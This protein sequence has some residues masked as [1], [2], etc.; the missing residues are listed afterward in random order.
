MSACPSLEELP[1]PP[2]GKSGWPWTEESARVVATPDRPV[3]RVTVITPSFNQ[4]AYVEETIRSVL[5]Q[6]YPDLEYFVLDGGSTDGSAE[7]IRNYAPW[8]SFWTSERDGGQSAAINR[9]LRLGTGVF[10]AWINSDDLLCKDA[11]G[12]LTSEPMDPRTV[13]IGDCPTIDGAGEM[14]FVQ[15]GRVHSLEDLVRI[16]SIWMRDGY[17][18][19][20]AVVFPLALALEVGA[21]DERNPLTMD[22]ELWGKLLLGGATIRYTGAPF[23]VFRHH[24]A[25]KTSLHLERQVALMIDDAEALLHRDR[26]VDDDLKRELLADLERY[27]RAYPDIHWKYSGRLARWGLPPAVVTPIRRMRQ[28]LGTVLK[29][30]LGT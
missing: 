3:P 8:L 12:Q 27:R 14:L 25:Q 16:P 6:G 13:Y 21:L 30:R 4:A 18:S 19:Q 2:R 11:L 5:L 17:I 23:G 29:G 28:G 7:I 22:Y 15:R 20:P 9:G 10:A 1:A 26:R 24:E